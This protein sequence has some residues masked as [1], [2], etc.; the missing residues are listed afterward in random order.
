MLAQKKP[1]E[2]TQSNKTSV[3]SKA[4]VLFSGGLDSTLVLK[5]LISEGVNV[6]AVTFVTPFCPQSNE[7]DQEF[8][9]DVGVKLHRIFLGEEF[10]EIVMNPRHGYGSRMNPCIDCRILMLKKAKQLADHIGADFLATGEV[11]NERPFSQRED[12]LFL[13]EKKADL[14]GK[15][16]RPLSAKLL[17]ETDAEKSGLIQREKML[18]ME[19]RRRLRQ[20][21]LAKALEVQ[22][23]P[24]PSGGCL[25]TEPRFSE[26]LKEHLS[27][28]DH[29]TLLDADLL[30]IGRHFRVDDLKVIVGRDKKE[31]EKLTSMAEKNGLSMMEVEGFMGPV[32]VFK[33]KP[34][35]ATKKKVAR[36]AVRY[37]DAPRKE[38]AKIKLKIPLN[39]EEILEEAVTDENE[40]ADCMI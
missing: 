29:L 32:T 17:P 6:E 8:C 12:A 5:L 30:K 19:G 34:R 14:Q 22:D 36:I 9:K 13:I 3:R 28:E 24:N 31:N 1:H 37:S 2:K 11:L 26:R 20:F 15:I 10:L 18:D 7:L 33:G 23:Y 4:L 27:H 40:F 35:E 16:L 39:G 38:S 25:L 21:E